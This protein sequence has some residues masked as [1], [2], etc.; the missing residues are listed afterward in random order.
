MDI[1]KD[2]DATAIYGSRGA[3]GV[4]LITTK[5]GKTGKTQFNFN[6]YTGGS[7]VVKTL[8]MLNTS[9]Y[10]QMRREAFAH[11]GVT[12]TTDN[13][14][15]LLLW[16]QT[17]TT[18]WQ[19]FMIGHT[20]RVTQANGSVSGGNAQTKFLLS[21]TYRD[22]T[23]VLAHDAG[24]KRGAI[25]LNVDHSSVDERFNINTS[26]NFT[27]D[28]NSSLATDIT[29]FYNLAPNYPLYDST[30]A[31]YWNSFTQNP[32][33]YFLRSST[34]RTTNL[35]ANTVLRY[36]LLPGLNLKAS[37]GYN[38]TNLDQIQAYPDKTFNP[39]TST[40]S[41]SYFGNSDVHSYTIEP[42]IDYTRKLGD[43]KL[44]LLAG[45]TW[46][47][48]LRQG[49]YL[50]ASG[51]SSDALLED[52][53]SA[54][55][56]I[57]QPSTYVFYR[58]NSFFG[59]ANYNLSDKYILNA[60]FRRDGSTRFG[61]GHRFGNFGAL[62]AAWIFTKESFFPANSPLSYGKLRGSYGTTGNDQ[63]GD[64]AYLDSW[65][66]TS[67][68]YDGVSGLSPARI[69][70][71]NYGWETNRKLEFGLELGFFKDR[72]LLN[73][74]FY[75]NIS[76]NQLIQYALSPQAGRDYLVANFPATVL[77]KGWEFELNTRNIQGRDFNWKT[78]FNLT[79]AKNKLQ[80]YPGIENSSYSNTYVVGQSLSIVKGYQ[81]TGVDPATGVPNF[82]DVNKDGAIAENDDYVVLGKTLPDYYGGLSNSLTYKQWSL[83]FLFQFV[84]QQGPTVNYGYQSYSYG[85]ADNKDL[86]ALRRWQK[87]G[88]ITDIPAASLT[89][90]NP[91]YDAYQNTYRFSSAVW[92]DASYIRL[93]NLSLNYDLSPYVKKWKLNGVSVYVLAQNLFTITSYKGFDPETQG[94]YLPPLKTITGG[95]K[96]SF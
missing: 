49:R 50:Q 87:P 13:A 28:K 7:K 45:G 94:T 25:H 91:V 47:Q 85:I 17:K 6:V 23:T 81:F 92:G 75:R 63:I 22:E 27:T 8:D 66:S 76:G 38:Q 12:P 62:G 95:I 24:Y 57:A 43:G 40:G 69:A 93:K 32:Q 29:Q 83:D 89:S 26:V 19:K 36:T 72:I 60:S 86:S 48:S 82:L 9:Q 71:P 46:Q 31:L 77:N 78:S 55:S 16:D 68:P 56:V 5:K 73:T 52:I 3:N 80:K 10:L 70:N 51:F 11:D 65:L 74:N 33:A 67:F 90:G 41:M 34:S 84:K 42:Q 53:Y 59:R 21:A 18:D 58:Y 30:G 14:P 79:I 64:Y 37:L 96:L 39:A 88:D 4:I 35:I 2:A 1:L 54:A 44:N 61:P 15:D 20:A